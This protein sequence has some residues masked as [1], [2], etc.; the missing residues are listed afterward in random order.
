VGVAKQ[1]IVDGVNGFLRNDM[2]GWRDALE[3]LLGDRELRA[4]MGEAARETV[5]RDYSLKV[6]G[7]RVA[8]IVASL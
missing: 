2:A 3:R 5:E 7:P 4:A 6:W 1:I 8:E